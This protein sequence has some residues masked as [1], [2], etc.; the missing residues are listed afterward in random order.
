MAKIEDEIKAIKSTVTDLEGK[1][2]KLQFFLIQIINKIGEGISA[3]S[4]GAQ[5]VST[6][7]SVNIDLTPLEERLEQLSKS[8]VSKADL[9]PINQALAKLHDNRIKEAEE[10]IDNVTV[11]LEKGLA[12]TELTSTLKE[13]ES[14]LQELVTP[15]KK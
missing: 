13:I 1:I 3:N 6:P 14:H 8:I 7:G 12:L 4:E 5:V 15:P 11:L 2:D 9:E 10:T